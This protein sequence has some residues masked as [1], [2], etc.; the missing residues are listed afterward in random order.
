MKL[1]DFDRLAFVYD[2]LAKLIFG[3]S[4]TES[5]KYFLKNIP[6]QSKI[7][8]LGGGTGEVLTELLTVKNVLICYIEASEK[9]IMMAKMK[10]GNDKRIQFIHGT[11]NDI[12][13]NEQ[14]DAVITNFY[15][16][17]FS[18]D[19]LKIVLRKIKK[20][21]TTRAQWIATD[22]INNTWWQSAMLKLMYG[23]FRMTCNIEARKLPEWRKGLQNVGAKEIDSRNYY[24]NFIQTSLFHF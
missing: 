23:F 24:G 8:I 15:L 19:S 12:P 21:I 1:N 6:D 13:S 17:L 20:S 14:F 18:D 4:I 22:F 10:S 16:D 7:L 3:K 9:M 5:Q 2:G 11:E